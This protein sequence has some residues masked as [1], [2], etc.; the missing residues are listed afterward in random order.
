MPCG[1]PGT[2]K[3]TATNVNSSVGGLI[4]EW[5][6]GSGW[7]DTNGNIM[8]SYLQTTSNTLSLVP[9]TYPLSN[10]TVTPI[11]NGVRYT[12]MT[13][14]VTLPTYSSGAGIN[15]GSTICNLNS[16]TTYALVLPP[17]ES[18]S[19]VV[20]SSSNTAIAT[21][22]NGTSTQVTVNALNTQ[23]T[24]TLTAVITNSCGQTSANVISK[25][26]KVGSSIP[27]FSVA[28]AS[29][30]LEIC[31]NGYHY[32]FLDVTP[33]DTSG[34]TYTYLFDNFI[35]GISNP[36]VT[37]VQLSAKTFRFKIPKNK[38]P[39]GAFPT[40]TFNLTGTSVCGNSSSI[41]GKTIAMDAAIIASCNAGNIPF[42][43]TSSTAKT[44]DAAL[45]TSSVQYIVYPNP[46][47]DILNIEFQ[48]TGNLEVSKSSVPASLY[49]MNG[50]MQQEIMI[51]ENFAT[52]NLKGLKKGIYILKINIEG[53]I[54]THRVFVN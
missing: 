32:L 12:K 42:T 36:G 16:A 7:K 40:L 5:Y 34:S 46:T 52:V 21:V 2:F 24:F 15:G 37:Y 50:V 43:T 22:S 47:S 10:I 1:S 38:I 48:Q 20:W 17:T 3:F 41:Y 6:A 30:Y 11:L 4:Y 18:N 14:T 35:T 53:N 28:K 19:T 26:I 27:N 54:E 29:G 9:N 49:D 31:G 44:T 51:K 33:N 13:C 23:G 45:E 8:G 39:T 25:T